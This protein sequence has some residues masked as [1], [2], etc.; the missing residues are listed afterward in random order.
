MSVPTTA[1]ALTL[2][3]VGTAAEARRLGERMHNCLA[4][5][6]GQLTGADR[7]VE[8]RR[9]GRTLYAVHVSR[10]RIVTFEAAGNRSPAQGDVPVVR[11]LLEEGGYLT[12][13]ATDVPP[14]PSER[15][16]PGGRAPVGRAQLPLGPRSEGRT[17]PPRRPPRPRPA[18]PVGLSVQQLATELLGPASLQSPDWTEVAAALWAVGTLPRLPSPDQV[19]FERVVR[20]LAA[21]VAVGDD[22]GSSRRPAPS[23]ASRQATRQ[24]LLDRAAPDEPQA[25]RLRRMAAVL[26]VPLRP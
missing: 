14:A 20:D 10:G 2:H 11:R 9:A 13:T 16:A 7:V 24:A 18:S 26:E 21:K 19:R 4:S 3:V 25:W 6:G 23:A 17:V 15:H 1:A 22:A 8:V 12:A 5:Y